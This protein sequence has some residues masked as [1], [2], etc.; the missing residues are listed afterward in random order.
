[1]ESPA[2]PGRFTLQRKSLTVKLVGREDNIGGIGAIVA[3]SNS[4]HAL[5]AQHVSG[6]GD[7]SGQS[8]PVLHFGLGDYVGP[9][10]VEVV[11]PLGRRQVEPIVIGQEARTHIEI[12]QDVDLEIDD[13]SVRFIAVVGPTLGGG[14]QVDWRFEWW[15]DHWSDAELEEVDI[16]YM[17]PDCIGDEYHL[18]YDPQGGV[19]AEVEY[20]VKGGVPAFRHVL[21]W[22]DAPC[23]PGCQFTFTVSSHSGLPGSSRQIS[24][25]IVG[26]MPRICPVEEG[27]E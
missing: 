11:W 9:I 4:S 25:S 5:G 17:P 20:A 15:T 6:E 27:G 3:L 22:I 13:A 16:S 18:Q 8:S 26:K 2:I 7:A 14:G 23:M 24:G 21:E 10:E 19:T 1:M 12:V